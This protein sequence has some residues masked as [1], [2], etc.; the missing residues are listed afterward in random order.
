MPPTPAPVGRC[1]GSPMAWGWGA[2]PSTG[3]AGEKAQRKPRIVTCVVVALPAASVA[4][5]DRVSR[6]PCLLGT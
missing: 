5:A 6:A 2:T 4:V 1:A 3:G